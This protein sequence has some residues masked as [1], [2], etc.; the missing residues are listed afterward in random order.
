M[1]IY[2]C[3]NCNKYFD[4]TDNIPVRNDF[5][6]YNFGSVHVKE[7]VIEYYCPDCEYEL[8]VDYIR[9]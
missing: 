7:P 3:Q 6:S 2:Y 5:I 1:K 9:R 8:Y 4:E